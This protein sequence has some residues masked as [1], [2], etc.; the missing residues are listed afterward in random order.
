MKRTFDFDDESCAAVHF[1]ACGSHTNM[2]IISPKEVSRDLISALRALPE[3]RWAIPPSLSSLSVRG[4]AAYR[5]RDGEQLQEA[6]QS[7][8]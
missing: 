4:D 1:H 3:E 6:T 8:L 7:L 5:C 2:Y